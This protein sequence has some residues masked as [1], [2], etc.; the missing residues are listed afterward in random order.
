MRVLFD[1]DVTLDIILERA[2]FVENA[3]KVW[4]LHENKKI[5]A[6]ISPITPINVFYIVKKQRDLTIARAAVHVL[7]QSLN[8][9]TI[10]HTTLVQAYESA[11]TDFE[12]ATQ[13][14]VALEA[15][16]DAIVTRN[17]TDYKSATLP[18]YSPAEFLDQYT[19]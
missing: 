10:S 3:K 9:C 14:A 7:L 17:P 2:P 1:T 13:H 6:Y 12:D 8:L 19:P 4:V 11:F 18:I 5:T 15:G 16:L